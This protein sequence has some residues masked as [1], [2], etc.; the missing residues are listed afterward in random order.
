MHRDEKYFPDPEA[1]K[2]ER[3]GFEACANRHPY[4]YIPFSAGKRNCIGQ[5]FAQMEDKVVM[6]NILRNFKIEAMQKY[7]ELEP[8]LE[9]ILRPK[10]G[11]QIRLL[12]RDDKI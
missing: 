1:F 11:I 2:P 3:F 9:I 8:D 4:A 7:D 5:K 12:Q 6:A 10:N